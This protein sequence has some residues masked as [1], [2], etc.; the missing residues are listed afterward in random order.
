M[1]TYQM[2]P[3]STLRHQTSELYIM[4]LKGGCLFED[5]VLLDEYVTKPRFHAPPGDPLVAT[6]ADP[7]TSEQKISLK[8]TLLFRIV[9][10]MPI[11]L[12]AFSSSRKNVPSIFS[13]FH[14]ITNICGS[15]VPKSFTLITI[16]THMSIVLFYCFSLSPWLTAE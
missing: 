7:C 13:N 2:T 10:S 9:V 8:K 15:F 12:R 3:S 11:V 16:L 5:R 14:F 6:S 4:E 1:T